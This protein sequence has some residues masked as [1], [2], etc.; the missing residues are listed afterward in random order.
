VDFTVTAKGPTLDS[1]IRDTS[2][3]LTRANRKAGREVRKVGL[4]AMRKGAP[5][6]WGRKLAIKGDV[7]A[8]ATKGATVEF[9]PA[10]NNAGGWAMQ[11]SGRR[12]GYAIRPKRGRTGRNG[13][14]PALK[15]GAIYAAKARGGAWGGRRAWTKAGERL[16]KALDRTVAD[17]YD[18]ALGA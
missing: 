17:V 15:I 10:P 7:T 11:E 16:A 18:D 6:M 4:A 2:R 12:G 13:R 8:T 5:R 1:L 9:F 14:R 3:D